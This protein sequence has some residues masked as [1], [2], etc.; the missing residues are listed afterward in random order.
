MFAIYKGDGALWN[1][2]PHD[3]IGVKEI[4]EGRLQNLSLFIMPGGRDRPYHAALKGRPNTLIRQFVEQGG[5]YLGICAGAYYG[6]SFVE[7]DQGF[8][9]EVCEERE[10]GFFPGKAVG[11]AY[12]KGTFAYESEKGARIAKIGTDKGVFYTYFNGGCTFVGDLTHVRILARYLDLPGEPPAIIEC[13][14]KKGKAI[15]S[16]VHIEQQLSHFPEYSAADE[17]KM[18]MKDRLARLGAVIR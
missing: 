4:L 13:P 12:G 8:P 1:G 7:F 9:L 18:E 3:R 5:V 2:P 17:M 6:C 11:P 15:L 10:L 16:G 14:L